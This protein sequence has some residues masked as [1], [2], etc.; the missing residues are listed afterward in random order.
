M[1]F[2][3]KNTIFVHKI[4]PIMTLHYS[5]L[6]K[7]MLLSGLMLFT[8]QTIV[9]QVVISEQYGNGQPKIRLTLHGNDT[10]C[11]EKI[12]ENGR[13]YA[14]IWKDSNYYYYPN[15]VISR[16]NYRQ[17]V[18]PRKRAW[19][20]MIKVLHSKFINDDELSFLASDETRT[21]YPDG[22][23]N[24]STAWQGDTLFT[25]AIYLPNGKLYSRI[26]YKKENNYIFSCS[27]IYGNERHVSYVDTVEQI[28]GR[29]G[30][31]N[32]KFVQG[33]S[34]DLKK[35]PTQLTT[36][37]FKYETGD[38]L[39]KWNFDSTKWHIDKDNALCL[40][41]FR[42]AQQ[43]WAIQPQ[44]ESIE[45]FN[46]SYYIA[47]KGGKYGIL[48]EYGQIVVPFDWDYLKPLPYKQLDHENY[49]TFSAEVV[50]PTLVYPYEWKQPNPKA[51][52]I[53]RK[54]KLYGVIDNCGKSTLEP[55]YQDVRQGK[56]NLYEVKI[57][58]AWGIVDNHGQIIVAPNYAEVTA[59]DL[60]DIFI[61]VDTATFR[62]VS[63]APLDNHRILG[64]IH[65]QGKTL[66]KPAFAVFR[67]SAAHKS[68]LVRAFDGDSDLDRKLG[69]FHSEKGMVLDPKKTYGTS[70]CLS[71]TYN[72]FHEKDSDGA[73]WFGLYDVAR[74]SLLLPF[75]YQSI[76]SIFKK[77]YNP[78]ST[79]AAPEAAYDKVEFYLCCKNGKYGLFDPKHQKWLLPLKYDVLEPFGDSLFWV[80]HKG[81][82]Q[83]INQ[84]GALALPQTFQKMGKCDVK[85][86]FEDFYLPI[87]GCFVPNKDTVLFY[88]S[89]SFPKTTTLKELALFEDNET[90]E[91]L[92]VTEALAGA[93]EE[94]GINSKARII[95]SPDYKNILDADGYWLVWHKPTRQ[96][97][98]IDK[99]GNKRPFLQ[100]Y[101]I[102]RMC[103]KEHSVLVSD[104]K[105]G[106]LGMM[107]MAEEMILPCH[108]FGM[109][110]M[111][112]MGIIWAR[113]DFSVCKRTKQAVI[114]PDVLGLIDSNWQMYDKKGKLLTN[115]AFDYPFE[116]SNKL[117][118]GQVNGKQ[119]IWNP[120][121]Q[122]ILPA[123]YDKIWYDSLHHIFHL[124]KL[125]ENKTYKVGFA[126]GRGQ[127]I[128]DTILL[129]MSSFC[130]SYAF[131]ET[132]N[133][134]GMIRQDGS[135]WVQPQPH[136][137]QQVGFSILDKMMA[138]ADS[139]N[140]AH[141]VRSSKVPKN[142]SLDVV[143][144]GM[145]PVDLKVF[146]K[147]YNNFRN[148]GKQLDTLRTKL[149]RAQVD[150][151]V[152]EQNLQIYFLE[153]QNT[154][155]QRNTN[156]F[157]YSNENF[158]VKDSAKNRYQQLIYRQHGHSLANVSGDSQTIRLVY[159]NWKMEPINDIFICHNFK[160]RNN[161]WKEV[162]LDSILGLNEA[163]QLAL[164]QLLF[165][166]VGLVKNQKMDCGN[167][168]QYFKRV[169]NRFYILPEGL[170]FWMP[171]SNYVYDSWENRVPL[172]LTW[173][174]LKPFLKL[175]FIKD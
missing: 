45:S 119:G 30:Y 126:N 117:G 58:N 28:Q 76:T 161:I 56:T 1:I 19:T 150:N 42:N 80:L 145:L 37:V 167:P 26:L 142:P 131:V 173:E 149:N 86:T 175:S 18:L 96:Q 63:N 118:I 66:L 11:I 174:E 41:G 108:F 13:L 105:T 110:E 36:Q 166:K 64:L 71:D 50:Q 124:F 146:S 104:P 116:W 79:C 84:K 61:T 155:Y 9:A 53:C 10:F 114:A 102:H 171:K 148:V 43:D 32:N 136:A 93:G 162:L 89:L 160:I 35:H 128:I 87:D 88:N 69:V 15:Q 144:E 165:Q 132:E 60:K 125:K 12:V 122:N 3:Q 169:Q 4:L 85:R 14:K 52:L 23:L 168:A 47:N 31:R 90:L 77:I 111:D 154:V 152:L 133:G 134:Y 44:Y 121:G 103:P 95:M 94:W 81:K 156:W 21:Y 151:L 141:Q 164:N 59:T 25:H 106:H 24:D 137:L 107:T 91:L 20:A 129:N 48:D 57:G 98:L 112:E 46:Q 82:Y 157:F 6:L 5:R 29:V 92:N 55:V 147:P 39:S 17:Q 65:A 16:K 70:F 100:Q 73:R 68:F 74:A 2:G 22:A 34:Y 49:F 72:I 123:V 163:N 40:Y 170:Q 54:G 67:S 138:A 158:Y 135:Y 130:G 7:R 143:I 139:I 159:A 62:D 120:Q 113:N 27:E 78:T 127:L 75:E 8:L 33:E 115:V 97:Q 172:L 83:F 51:Q 140:A 101:D 38:L 109:T 153:T 99:Q